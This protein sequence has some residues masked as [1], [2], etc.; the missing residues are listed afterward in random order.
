MAFMLNYMMFFALN[1]RKNG[2]VNEQVKFNG[3]YGGHVKVPG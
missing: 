2:T 3:L 1:R